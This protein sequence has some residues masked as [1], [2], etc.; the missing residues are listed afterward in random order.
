MNGPWSLE[1]V[2]MDMLE[3]KQ[4]PDLDVLRHGVEVHQRYR[5]LLR[6]LRGRKPVMYWDL[7]D[8]FMKAAKLIPK[9]ERF[10]DMRRFHLFHDCGKPYSMQI[11]DGNKRFP[12]HEKVSGQVSRKL[13]FKENISQMIELDMICHKTTSE[14]FEQYKNHPLLPSLLLT[15]IAEV[16]ANNRLFGGFDSESFKIKHKKVLSRLKQ[17]LE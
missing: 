1:D 17:I 6:L 10:Q 4:G 12:D 7:P 9:Q 16:Y 8:W 2:I 15:S 5:D 3:T 14:E 11:E 13:K